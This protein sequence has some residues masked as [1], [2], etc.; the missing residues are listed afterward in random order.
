MGL[1]LRYVGDHER[2]SIV[3][4]CAEPHLCLVRQQR[5]SWMFSTLPE[6]HG[7]PSCRRN[8]RTT[9]AYL[10]F[11]MDQNSRLLSYGSFFGE[12]EVHAELAG[13][14]VSLLTPTVRAEDIPLHTHK[15]ASF[16]LVLSGSYLST[17]D[18]APSRSD[19]PMLIYNP[20]GT[21]HR[22]TFDRP[23]GR[24]LA[25]SISCRS[26]QTVKDGVLMPAAAT[27]F[28]SGAAVEAAFRL[29]RACAAQERELEP[30]M[31]GLCWEL[32]GATAGCEFLAA[33]NL[34]PW[35][36]RARELL[37]DRAAEPMR[38]AE[39]AGQ[40]GVHPVHFA[41]VFRRAFRCTPGE[42]LMRCR[43][44]R[45]MSMVR[46][47]KLG[48]SEIALQAGF[49]DQSH[50]SRAF[51]QH[52]GLPPHSYRRQIRRERR[53]MGVQSVQEFSAE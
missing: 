2:R 20:E 4:V 15:N 40:L 42:Y 49:F 35:I 52:F 53:S 5:V 12:G 24:F 38:I 29:A 18:G 10:V 32:L 13:F 47:E 17:A 28:F 6:F 46:S 23:F 9:Y 51:R 41:R 33:Q 11:T 50:L 16:V 21:T 30:V 27:S 31:E 37:H 43:L 39:M 19:R 1:K 36:R 45:A 25:V 7:Y 34:P 14:S 8:S 26:L 3:T 44:Q 22:D 48:L